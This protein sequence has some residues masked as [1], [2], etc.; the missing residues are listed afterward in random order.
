MSLF[1]HRL[2]RFH[3]HL[4]D[5]PLAACYPALPYR[6]QCSVADITRQMAGFTLANVPVNL[7]RY[8]SAATPCLEAL[9]DPI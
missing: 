8:G 4:T 5:A 7:A 1:L 6:A 2:I 9:C 3:W